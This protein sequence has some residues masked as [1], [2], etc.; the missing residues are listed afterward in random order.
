MIGALRQLAVLVDA[1]GE[2]TWKSTETR[3][4]RGLFGA[5]MLA[6][7]ILG[8]FPGGADFIVGRL[9]LMFEHLSR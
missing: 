8:L 6:L 9:P 2:N 4:E 5:G 3:A 1:G 7:M